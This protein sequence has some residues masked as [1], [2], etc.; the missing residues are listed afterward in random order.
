VAESGGLE[1]VTGGHGEA[2]ELSQAT[3]RGRLWPVAMCP[4]T[5]AVSRSA[6]ASGWLWGDVVR[7]R[8]VVECRPSAATAMPLM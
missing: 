1:R 3:A 4:A 8:V 2:G 5:A 7:P 6:D